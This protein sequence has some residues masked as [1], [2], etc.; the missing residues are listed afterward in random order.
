MFKD[1]NLI[2]KYI[3]QYEVRVNNNSKKQVIH[4]RPDKLI[5]LLRTI[6]YRL[7]II[8]R[9]ILNPTLVFPQ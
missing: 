3:I 5:K 7:L 6:K 4:F 2:L 9:S 8:L 1:K